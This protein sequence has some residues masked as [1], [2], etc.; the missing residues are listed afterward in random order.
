MNSIWQQHLLNCGASIE[1][2]CVVNFGNPIKEMASLQSGAV[3]IDLSDFGLISFSGED[4]QIFLQGQLTNDIRQVNSGKSQYSSYCTPKGRMLANF[5]IWQNDEHGYIMQLPVELQESIQKRLSMFVMRSK[6]KVTDISGLSIRLG[7]AGSNAKEIL[8]NHY[9]NVP[10][11]PQEVIRI[12]DDT[13]INLPGNRFEIITIPENAANLWDALSKICTP[14]GSAAWEWYEIQAGIPRITTATQEQ[15]V[16]QMVNYEVIGGVNFQKGCYPGQEIVA[17]TQYLGKLKR[18]MYLAHLNTG[19]PAA[20]D[21]LFSPE[22]EGQ[23]SG[24]VVNVFPSPKG[25]YDLL[26]VIQISSAAS[27]TIH[28][29]TLDGPALELQQ[30]PYALP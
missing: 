28:W 26:A 2:N 3:L 24:M 20:G 4:S 10:E 6:V 1:A 25:G 7:I 14:V 16:P 8:Q 23:A 30:L 18:R 12:G 11:T 19:A 17:R 9:G 22:M 27:E 13:I 5:L 21:D 29:K 15:F